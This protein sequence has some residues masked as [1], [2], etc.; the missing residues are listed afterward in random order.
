M[1]APLAGLKLG[2]SSIKAYTK[3]F[4]MMVKNMYAKE[5][6]MS[7]Q[8][9]DFFEAYSPLYVIDC[10]SA[11]GLNDGREVFV[12][13]PDATIKSNMD[14]QCVTIGGGGFMMEG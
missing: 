2:F 3:E 12:L 9:I 4:T 13:Y 5:H 8:N 11:I 7:R 14:D 1:K 10:V 6:C